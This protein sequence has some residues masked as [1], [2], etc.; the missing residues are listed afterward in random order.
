[1]KCYT[2][3][4]TIYILRLSFSRTILVQHLNLQIFK[5]NFTFFNTCNNKKQYI[6]II[7]ISY[8]YN[9]LLDNMDFKNQEIVLSSLGRYY[10]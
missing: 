5:I 6:I 10:I 8:L 4:I 1:M 3:T 2:V 7:C 9:L